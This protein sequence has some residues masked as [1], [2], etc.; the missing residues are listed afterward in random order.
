MEP[1]SRSGEIVIDKPRVCIITGTEP[2]TALKLIE[3][4]GRTS[5]L[6]EASPDSAAKFVAARIKDGH[7][8]IL[9]H[10][11]FSARFITDRAVQNEIVRHRLAS[12]TV[13]STRFCDYAKD[14]ILH[15]IEPP[16]KEEAYA[17]DAW[18]DACLVAANTYKRLRELALD[19]LSQAKDRYPVI[20]DD[21]NITQTDQ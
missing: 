15:F 12:Y 17:R 9:E 13:E 7:E 14:G 16:F 1:V 20:F 8:S 18:I 21:I 10:A 11:G 19:L 2:N 4:A 3:V 5:Y 6:S